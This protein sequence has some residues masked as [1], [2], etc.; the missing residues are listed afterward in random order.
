VIYQQYLIYPNL[1]N[2]VTTNKW[3]E[4]RLI[5]TSL[6]YC[7]YLAKA[8]EEQVQN[9]QAWGIIQARNCIKQQY[10]GT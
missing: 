7:F 1:A 10:S 5:F 3:P 9:W 8:D 4:V 6:S 2:H